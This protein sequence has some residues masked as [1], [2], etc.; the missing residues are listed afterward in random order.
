MYSAPTPSAPFPP[1][2]TTVGAGVPAPALPLPA[3]VAALPLVR[4]GGGRRECLLGH[5]RSA[6]ATGDAASCGGAGRLAHAAAT[7]AG[8]G[9]A[10]ARVAI[11]RPCRGTTAWAEASTGSGVS[12]ISRK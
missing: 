8:W 5:R 12:L 10:P 1:E 2:G 6:H 9:L 4:R 3:P 7:L 11:R